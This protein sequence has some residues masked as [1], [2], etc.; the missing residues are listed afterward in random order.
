MIY[1]RC[2]DPEV[3]SKLASNNE[4]QDEDMLVCDDSTIMM[5]ISDNDE[6]LVEE[7]LEVEDTNSDENK[8]THQIH[9]RRQS[10]PKP[11]LSN[12]NNKAFPQSKTTFDFK[13][14]EPQ[15]DKYVTKMITK[16]FYPYFINTLDRLCKK[17]FRFVHVKKQQI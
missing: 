10:L 15:D 17:A 12:K 5:S 6:E 8:K 1:F 3:V 11:M 2:L 4:S 7:I 9:H 16:W 14:C 13:N